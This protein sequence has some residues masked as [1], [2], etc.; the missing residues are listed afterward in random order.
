MKRT[1]LFAL[2]WMVTLLIWAG[3]V[4]P[5]QAA[6]IARQFLNSHHPATNTAGMKMAARQSMEITSAAEKTAYYVFN[7]GQDNGYV[8]V[9]GSDLAPKV[10]AYATKGSFDQEKMPENMRAWLQGYADQ[11]AYLE[12]TQGAY[13]A[14]RR[15]VERA[16]VAPLLATTWGQGSPYNALCPMEGDEQTIAGCVAT[17]LAQV[18]YYYRWP[19]QTENPI[20]AYTTETLDIEMP[21]IGITTID[22]NNI[23]DSYTGQETEAQKKAVAQ[24]M[25]LCGQAV[26]MDY[27]T[28]FSGANMGK[29]VNALLHYFGYDRTASV[30]RREYFSASAWE[31]VIYNEIAAKRPVIYGGSSTTSGHSFVVDGYRSDGYFHVNWGWNG[32]DD[33]YFLLSVL[34][35]YNN[36]DLG[37]NSSK[38]GY[39]FDQ[40]AVVGIQYGTGEKVAERLTLYNILV[41]SNSTLTR[42]AADQ[43]FSGVALEIYFRNATSYDCTFQTGVVVQ[44]AEGNWLTGVMNPASPKEFPNSQGLYRVFRFSFGANLPNGDYYLVPVC[45]SANAADWESCWCSEVYRV[46]A[47]INDNTLTLTG[48]FFSLSLGEL[49]VVGDTEVGSTVMLEAEIRNSGSYFNEDIML[50]VDG[51]CVAGR[52][53]DV[54]EEGKAILN[55]DYVPVKL[56]TNR[57]QLCYKIGYGDNYVLIGS[58]SIDVTA[59]P[60]SVTQALEIINSLPLKETSEKQYVVRGIVTGTVNYNSQYHEMNFS[61]KDVDNNNQ[62]KIYRANSFQGEAITN[63]DLVK[64][65]DEIL[66]MGCLQNYNSANKELVYGTILTIGDEP[67]PQDDAITVAEARAIAATLENKAITTE[68][69]R[70]S[71]YVVDN[72]DIQKRQDGS[73]YGNAN[74]NM[75][76]EPNGSTTLYGYRV[77]GLDNVAIQSDDY[78]QKGDKIVVCGQLQKW[79][80]TLEVVNGYLVSLERDASGIQLMTAEKPHQGQRYNLA[81]QKVNNNYRGIVI[82]N[83]RKN[84]S[85]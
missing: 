39:S 3:N 19:E 85:K 38:D 20:P 80:S 23:L 42:T 37:S 64:A 48:P 26:E 43:D 68:F 61:L 33:G 32:N 31:N 24:L 66:I 49:K 65:G 21:E 44:D 56:G 70:I 76:D 25:L 11:I 78:I 53:L 7:V 6:Q 41:Y 18:M 60:I 67:V 84:V 55:I 4:T 10:L 1:L 54:P 71:G 46:K 34:N 79:N 81:G 5:E 8:M 15:V 12:Q 17:A 74:F 58:G 45:K 2:S 27:T 28:K 22:W 63:A 83:G 73:Y 40:D 36:A 35:P 77:R 47:T 9:S 30:L 52:T 75:A 16:D 14:P 29:D 59:N 82:V 69:Y 72:P 62:I 50:L 51:K 57:L 13:E